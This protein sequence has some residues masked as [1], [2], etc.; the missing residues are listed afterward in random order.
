MGHAAFEVGRL[1]VADVSEPL[2]VKRLA[3]PTLLQDI[4]ARHDIYE[5]MCA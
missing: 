5:L 2:S 3:A 1:P 4:G